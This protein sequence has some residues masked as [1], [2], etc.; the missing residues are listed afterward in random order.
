MRQLTESDIA[1]LRSSGKVSQNEAVILEGDLVI[2]V[3]AQSGQRRVVDTSGLMLE[4]SKQ[5]LLD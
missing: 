5:L 4:A 3:D 2:A 1:K